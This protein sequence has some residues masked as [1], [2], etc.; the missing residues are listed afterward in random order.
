MRLHACVGHSPK[1][2]EGPVRCLDIGLI[3]HGQQKMAHCLVGK[4]ISNRLV[5]CEA[6]LSI[7]K[8]IWWVQ[9]DFEIEAMYGNIFA[10][11]FNNAAD[12]AKVLN[13]GPWSFDRNLIVLE[14]PIGTGGISSMNFGPVEFWVQIHNVSLLCMNKRVGLFLGGMIGNVKD[15]DA[16]PSG[17]CGGK[18]VW[19]RV[20]IEIAKPLQRCLCVDLLVD[21]KVTILLLRVEVVLQVPTGEVALIGVLGLTTTLAGLDG[22]ASKEDGCMAV[23]AVECSGQDDCRRKSDRESKDKV[24]AI[25]GKRGLPLANDEAVVVCKKFKFQVVDVGTKLLDATTGDGGLVDCELVVQQPLD[26]SSTAAGGDEVLLLDQVEACLGSDGKFSNGKDVVFILETKSNN[27][28]LERLLVKAGLDGKLV[29]DAVGRSDGL[30]LFWK[31]SIVVDLLSYSR[32]HIDV[33]IQSYARVEWLKCG[34]HNTRFFHLKASVRRPRNRI[35]GLYGEDGL[36]KEI[37]EDVE[38]VVMQYF[39][40]L[41]S[42]SHSSQETSDSVLAGVEPR[43]SEQSCAFLD[44]PFTGWR[45]SDNSLWYG[46]QKGSGPISLCNVLYKI[47]AKAISNRLQM[48]LDSVILDTQSAFI[49]EGLS[50]LLKRAHNSG[51]FSGFRCSRFGPVVTHLFFADDSLLFPQA[52]VANCKVLK[53]VLDDYAN[54]SG[55]MVN[56]TKSGLCV[57]SMVNVAVSEKLAAILGFRVVDCH[58]RYLGLPCYVGRDKRKLFTDIV[59]RIWSKLKG[60]QG[61]NLSIG[62]TGR[63]CQG[64]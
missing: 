5:N 14:E 39:S 34:D 64:D 18:F 7:I 38:N 19:V 17:G 15:I 59:D 45:N 63:S 13:G 9:E 60:W 57:S 16:G 6:F 11:Y 24:S 1:E 55:Q 27:V 48:V 12:R 46:A 3:E 21:G 42:S 26:V 43:L 53:R 10:F 49:P 31:N 32:F 35:R 22:V 20:E 4:V 61:K 37:N 52:T 62:A 51:L 58:E 40:A 44:G 30:C 54:A 56:Y 8:K 29:V 41:F 25:L 2:R 36:W 33:R 50:C 47:I 28:R 23:G